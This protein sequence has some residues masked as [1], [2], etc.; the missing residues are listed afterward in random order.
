MK[1][2]LRFSRVLLEMVKNRLDEVLYYSHQS[3]AEKVNSATTG[4]L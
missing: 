1:S 2:E 4:K 3:Y